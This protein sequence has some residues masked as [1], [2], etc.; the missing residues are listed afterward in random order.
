MFFYSLTGGD[1]GGN[2]SRGGQGGGKFNYLKR[3]DL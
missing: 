2:Q 3:L 1:R